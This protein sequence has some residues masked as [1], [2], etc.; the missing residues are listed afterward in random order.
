MA[1]KTKKSEESKQLSLF[2]SGLDLNSEITDEA[3]DNWLEGDFGFDG[4]SDRTIETKSELLTLKLLREAIKAQN[5]DD[6]V[7]ADF[8]EYVLPNLLSIAIGVTAKGG[9]F[10]D[11]IDEKRE[12]EGKAKVRRDNAADQSLN[13]HLLN[14][15]FPANLIERRLHKLDT[16]V[17]RVVRERERRLVIAGFIL[18]DFEKF[19]DVPNDCRKLPLEEHRQIIDEKVRQ[20]GLDKFIDSENTEAYKEYID[21][22]L[23]MAY[24]AQRRWDTNWN[25]SEFGLNPLLKDR[26]LRSLSDLTCLADSLASIIKHPQDAENPRLNEI[27]HSLSDGKLKFT[28]HRISENRGVLTNVVN[29]ALIQ[30]HTKLNTDENIYYEPLLYLPTGV[31][32][33]ARR[34]APEISLDDVPNQVIENIKSLCSG[35]LKLRQTGFGRDGKGMKY[36]EY[37]NLFFDEIGLMKVALD[38]TLRILNPNKDSVAK[39]RSDNLVKFQQQKVLSVDYDFKFTDDIR[40]DQIAEFGDLICRKI[41]DESANRIE[42]ACKKDKNLPKL[43]QLDLTYKVAE[44]WELAE[45]LP[46]IREIQRINESLKENKL[47]GNTG[48][49]PYEWYYLAAKFLEKHPG[50][51]NVRESCQQVI[52]YINNLISPIISQYELP[53]GW[54]DLRLWVKQVV[55][56]PG[57]QETQTPDNFLNELANYNAAKKSG[58]GR[59]L[60]CSISHSAYTVTEQMESAVLFTPQVYTNKQ[61]LNGSNAKRNISSIA[62]LEM[63]LRQILM[64]QTQAVGKRFEDGK[65]RYLYFY[66]TYYFTPETNKFLQKAYTGISQTRF[67][68]RIR[69]H[70]ISKDLQANFDKDTYQNVDAFLIDENLDSDKD[71]TFKLS[72]PDDQP[73]TFYFMAMP[74]G[75]DSSDTESWVMPTWLAFAFPMI[76]DVKT[77]VSESPIP[78]FNDGAEFEESVFLD[79]APHAFRTLVGRDRFRLDY[80]LEGWTEN[81]KSY[82]APLNVLTAAY[83]IH[84]DVN[85]KSGKSGYDA[86]WGRFTELAKDFETTPLYVFAYLNRWVRSQG[87][88]TARIEKIRLYAHKFY[89][90]FDPYAQYDFESKEWKLMPE[91]QLNHPKKLTDLYRKFYRAN[92]RYNPKSNAVLKPIDIAAETILKAE[93]SVFSGETL[94]AAVAAEVFKLMDRVHANTADGRWVMSKREEERQAVLDFARYFVMDVFENSFSSDR[95]RLA[96]RQLNLIKDTCEFLYRLEDDKENANKDVKEEENDKNED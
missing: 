29:N 24:N 75:R 19:P 45:Y 25:F 57:N 40:I 41:W 13:T 59:Q 56:L 20:L 15:L 34:D 54:N 5:P 51:E 2:E 68:T 73:L 12:A 63:M 52:E 47:K 84:I 17:Q 70:F 95:A 55:M 18:H 38:A 80:I 42:V 96:G 28:Y 44:F 77:V 22:L 71:R 37:Y 53:D 90:C 60:I 94:V 93:V 27:I 23:C 87:V 58:R 39:S 33:L 62:G 67:D 3:D 9:K 69:N 83:A 46:Q 72:Y 66:P 7:M 79:S 92:K 14:G 10:F 11:E 61:M 76:L 88:E 43:T 31:I 64:N 91:S 21:D 8:G 1:K 78:P 48:G 85:A 81:N 32:Y 89:P 4:D 35:Q 6:Q 82:P 74:P 49:V 50:I 86:N 36:A 30:V 16:T 26:T 65:Y